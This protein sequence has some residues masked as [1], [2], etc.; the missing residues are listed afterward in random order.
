MTSLADHWSEGGEWLGEGEHIVTVAE[1]HLRPN[2]NTGNRG[3]EFWFRGANNRQQKEIFW[4]TDAA[5][6]RLAKFAQACGQTQDACKTYDPYND[7][8]HARLIGSRVKI[9]VEPEVG[10]DNKTYHVVTGF[11]PI[12]DNPH[13]Q[14]AVEPSAPTSPPNEKVDRDIPF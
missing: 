13:P 8:H 5:L 1:Y 2:P 12:D 14:P 10:K 4:L 3:V 6:W 7:T 9:Q 11:G